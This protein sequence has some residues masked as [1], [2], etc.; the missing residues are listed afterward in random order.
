LDLISNVNHKHN[1]QFSEYHYLAYHKFRNCIIVISL[2]F[3]ALY[4]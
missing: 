3:M 1:E 4:E 2:N